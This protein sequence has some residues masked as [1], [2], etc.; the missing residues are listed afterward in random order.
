MSEFT[1]NQCGKKATISS[2]RE[3]GEDYPIWKCSENSFHYGIY[4]GVVPVD[5][6]FEE[7]IPLSEEG[8]KEAIKEIDASLETIKG[9]LL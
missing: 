7:P 5:D 8:F 6:L 3:D 9:G 1:C 4:Y 2:I